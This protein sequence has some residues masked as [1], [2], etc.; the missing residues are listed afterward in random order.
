MAINFPTNPALNDTY[1]YQG[2]S[3]QWN[4]TAWDIVQ[5]SLTYTSVVNGLGYPPLSIYGGQIQ[6]ELTTTGNVSVGT[7]N[8]LTAAAGKKVLSVSGPSGSYL[9]LGT[10]GVGLGSVF[11]DTNF[12]INGST[13]VLY[14]INSAAN[15]PIVFQS[16]SSYTERMRIDTSGHFVPGAT[17]TYD[18]GTS[19]L[20]WRNIYTNDLNLSNGIGDYTVIEGEEDLFLVNNKSGKTFKFALIEVDPSIVPPKSL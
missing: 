10:A 17:S 13:G 1:T 20:R 16:G 9:T 15:Q 3:W 14:I 18:L 5:A 11:A 6:G 8:V 4:G 7:A 19:S 12:G 2:N